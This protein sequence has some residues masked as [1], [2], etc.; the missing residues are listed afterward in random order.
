MIINV[1][2]NLQTTQSWAIDRHGFTFPVLLD[3]DG[4][5]ATSFAP[6]NILPALPR[7]EVPIASNLIIDPQGKIQFYTLLDSR[8]FDAELIELTQKLKQLRG[9]K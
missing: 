9:E 5:V 2:E 7:H 6:G 3:L 8:N 4:Q 1:K